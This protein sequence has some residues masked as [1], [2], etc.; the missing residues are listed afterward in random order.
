MKRAISALVES[1]YFFV[2]TSLIWWLTFYPG[3]Y[4]SD[5]F[6][7]LDQAKTGH[8]SNIYTSAW[9]LTLRILTIGGRVPGLATLAGV[10]L[11]SYAVTYF[12]KGAF[13][14]SS[15][16]ITAAL[17]LVMP[18]VGAM[19]ITLWHDIPMTAGLLISLS[20][21][22]R[23][24]IF[25]DRIERVDLLH[26]ILASVLAT[27]RPNGLATLFV[28]F[29]LLFLMRRSWQVL[30]MG[31]LTIIVGL[32]FSILTTW[33]AGEAS[34]VNSVYGQEWM[35]SDIACQWA[36]K[37]GTIPE[38]IQSKME[39]IAPLSQWHNPSG[40]TFLNGLG[41][42]SDQLAR[43]IE[44]VPSI[45]L[46]IF[47]SD[48]AGVFETH[49]KR[50]AYLLPL[51]TTSA[52]HPPFI[53]STIESPDQGISFAQP[54]IVKV[55]RPYVRIWNGLRPITAYAGLWL[56]ILVLMALFVRQSRR[57]TIPA[58]A[59]CLAVEGILF[60]FAPIP[61]GRYALPVLIVGQA[62]ALGFIIDFIFRKRGLKKS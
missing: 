27:Y 15:G 14:N 7:A 44:T 31:S 55:F 12:C 54:G 59:L 29:L 28:F 58:L 25:R 43:S 23:S 39:R 50:N 62:I 36:T 32:F 35:R 8:I 34:L 48:P 19:G 47:K 56:L 42:T 10:L 61:D 4:S 3:F 13:P 53:H 46:Q 45:W 11:L 26:F 9:P 40:C 30:K 20:V 16:K 33:A 24:S 37:P 41:F 18:L 17:L 38:A 5:S 1:R 22:I 60:V 21:V 6:G 49:A 52:M 57:Y 2:L 51:P